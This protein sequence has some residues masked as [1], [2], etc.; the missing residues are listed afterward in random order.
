MKF[1]TLNDLRLTMEI[2]NLNE[3]VNTQSY[4]IDEAESIALE[5]VKEY[6][7]KICDIDFELRAI[8]NYSINTVYNDY[9]RIRLT[10]NQANKDFSNNYSINLIDSNILNNGSEIIL[11]KI[12]N[13]CS[14]V[15]DFIPIPTFYEGDENFTVQNDPN[16]SA[17]C[18][19]ITTLDGTV[20][21]GKIINYYNTVYSGTSGVAINYSTVTTASA[22]TYINNV[23]N[24]GQYTYS[25]KDRDFL[26]DDRNF[27][28]KQIT[29]DLMKYLLFQRLAPKMINQNVVDRYN[30]SIDKLTRA[31]QAKIQMNLKE[32][33][34]SV[35]F[36]NNSSVRFGWSKQSARF[37]Y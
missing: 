3:I 19:V 2:D 6:L 1:L 28:L 15:K 34:N 29:I 30:M 32:I 26:T 9:D 24:F 20:S 11:V 25:N 18:G 27:S 10:Y 4:L 21:T 33:P 14:P 22:N 17:T 37:R 31:S 36:Q 8:Q 13:T 23:S 12:P 7:R 16:Y 35:E 5:N